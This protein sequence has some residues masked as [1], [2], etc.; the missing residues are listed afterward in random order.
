MAL[1]ID[2]LFSHQEFDTPA[3]VGGSRRSDLNTNGVGG[4]VKFILPL[5]RGN[6]LS[7]AGLGSTQVARRSAFFW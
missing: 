5:D 3:Y 6:C 7:E 2:G 1:E 4:V